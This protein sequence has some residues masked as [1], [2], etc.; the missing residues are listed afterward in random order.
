MYMAP[1]ILNGLPHDYSCDVWSIGIIMYTIL[2]GQMPFN[3]KRIDDE[4]KNTPILFIGPKWKKISK[5]AQNLI[6]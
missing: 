3:F 1:E 6:C 5:M 2:S 4:I